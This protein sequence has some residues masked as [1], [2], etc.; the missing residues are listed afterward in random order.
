M[1]VTLQQVGWDM[2]QFPNIQRWFQDCSIIP[3][4]EENIEGAKAFSE[5][6][7]KNLKSN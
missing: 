3:G 7:K 6:V 5:L 1:F 4:Y 2:S